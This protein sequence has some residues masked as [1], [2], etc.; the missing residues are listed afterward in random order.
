MS[1][2]KKFFEKKK[3]LHWRNSGVFIV[4]F[5]NI[6]HSLL[7]LTSSKQMLAG[8]IAMCYGSLCPFVFILNVMK[9]IE[10]EK[11]SYLFAMPGVRYIIMI[12]GVYCY[13]VERMYIPSKL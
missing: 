7:L 1:G 4:N 8:F 2:K 5:E 3:S 9:K 11:C 13:M 10:E 12:D 6:S